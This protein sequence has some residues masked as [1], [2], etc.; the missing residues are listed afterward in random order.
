MTYQQIYEIDR[1][2]FYT[3]YSMPVW[4]RNFYFRYASKRNEDEKRAMDKARGAQE[5]T[6]ISK[7]EMATVPGFVASQASAR[8]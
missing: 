5:G 3:L 2:D 8:G 4:L 6:P 1:F 7:K